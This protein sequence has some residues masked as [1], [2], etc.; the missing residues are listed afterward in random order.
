MIEC[1]AEELANR[2]L[3]Q[4]KEK[5]GKIKYPI[6]PFKLLKDEKVIVTT[7]D[8]ENLEGIILKDDDGVVIVGINKNRRYQ[9]Q[10]FTAAHEYCHFIKDLGND[11]SSI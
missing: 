6:D 2:V 11:K 4:I 8:F 10:R 9:R 5:Y 3:K 7:S 1:S